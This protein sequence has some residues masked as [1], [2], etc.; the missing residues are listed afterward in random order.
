MLR[1]FPVVGPAQVSHLWSAV[2]GRQEPVWSESDLGSKAWDI[3]EKVVRKLM[4]S[5]EG[6]NSDGKKHVDAGV[7]NILQTDD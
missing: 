5:G 4:R 7:S 6:N 2:E 3:R 1:G